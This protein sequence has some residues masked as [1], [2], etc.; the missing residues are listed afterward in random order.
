MT[1]AHRQ[2]SR[3]AAVTLRFLAEPTHVNFGGK[4]HGGAVMKWI[5]QAGYTC[6]AGW[7]GDYCVTA[8]VGGIRFLQ[9]INVGELVEVRAQIIRTGHTSMDVADGHLRGATRKSVT[10]RRACHCVMVFVGDRRGGRPHRGAAVVTRPHRSSRRWRPTRAR[11]T[12]LRKSMDQEIEARLRWLDQQPPAVVERGEPAPRP[13]A[14]LVFDDAEVLDVAGPFEVFSVA[15]R[16]HGLAPFLVSLVAEHPGPVTL[17]NGFTVQP[18]ATLA[19]TPRTG[20][21]DR[22]GGLRHPAGDAQ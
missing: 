22:P 12:D 5:D 1:A 15:G 4:V 21:P 19:Q 20:H 14:L 8:Y 9:P 6:A 2:P 7:T 3:P 16:R 17:R 11:L 13:V 10:K 18:H